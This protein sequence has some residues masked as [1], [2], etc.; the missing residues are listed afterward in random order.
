M[1]EWVKVL[2]CIVVLGIGIILMLYL[3]FPMDFIFRVFFPLGMVGIVILLYL[4]YILKSSESSG[5]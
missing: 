3:N 1:V 5:A 4:L 2:I